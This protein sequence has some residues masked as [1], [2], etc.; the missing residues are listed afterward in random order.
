MSKSVPIW[1]EC[2]LKYP[3]EFQGALYCPRV[4]Q[5]VPRCPGV[6]QGVP[7]CPRVPQG[8]PKCSN[9]S[10]I[11]KRVP[12][13]SRSNYFRFVDKCVFIIHFLTICSISD[14]LIF[15]LN[16][17]I[18]I[19]FYRTIGWVALIIPFPFHPFKNKFRG[20]KK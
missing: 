8:V 17:L 2:G 4:S 14:I 13:L 3:K 10:Q 19:H 20:M 16:V 18:A 11:S 1:S 5:G 9:V 15:F 6:S 7:M 12:G